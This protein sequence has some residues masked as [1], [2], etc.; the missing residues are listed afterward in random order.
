MDFS[1]MDQKRLAQE[2]IDFRRARHRRPESAWT[3]FLTTSEIIGQLEQLGI[4]YKMGREIH[5]S[6]ERYGV[7][8]DEELE[9]CMERALD[10]GASPE[11]VGRMRGGYTGVVGIID[12]GRPGPVTA[13]RFD[14]DCNDVGECQDSDHFPAR[15][16]FA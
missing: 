8:P 10:E 5:T 12:T 4:P 6:G 16:G 1:K 15:E 2:L 14:I 9:R 13:L 7:P 11:L 3:E